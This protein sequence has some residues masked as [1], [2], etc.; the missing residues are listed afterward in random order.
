MFENYTITDE[1]FK[2]KKDTNDSRSDKLF[3]DVALN[4]QLVML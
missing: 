4:L 3:V 1:T 2:K